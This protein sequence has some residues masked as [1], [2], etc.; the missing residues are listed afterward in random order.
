M[1]LTHLG[2]EAS[3]TDGSANNTLGISPNMNYTYRN[4]LIKTNLSYATLPIR[5]HYIMFKKEN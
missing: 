5:S 3:I 2:L 4:L 1:E